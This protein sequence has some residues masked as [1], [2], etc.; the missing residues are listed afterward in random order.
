MYGSAKLLGGTTAV[1]SIYLDEV[2]GAAWDEAG[3]AKTRQNMAV[4]NDWITDACA[5]Y[6]VT[7]TLYFDDGSADSPLFF[8]TVFNG[9]LI[10]GQEGNESE[11]LYNTVDTLCEALDSDRIRAEYNTDS[12]AYMVFLPVDGVSF[13]MVHYR[14]YGMAYYYEYSILYQDDALAPP[15]S[16]DTPL[17]YAHELLHQFGAADLYEG[18]SDTF[19]TDEMRAWIRENWPKAIMYN[20]DN[21]DNFNYDAIDRVLSPITAYRLGLCADFEGMSNFPTLAPTTPG[22]FDNA[23]DGPTESDRWAD[24]ADSG[25]VA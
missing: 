22:V 18:S 1:V 9:E 3:I 5:A 24:A 14:D 21:D 17:V 8:H 15:D 11:T 23:T 20:A 6:D 25:L 12:V 19:V 16:F 7:P 13:T 10:G 4:V 2:G